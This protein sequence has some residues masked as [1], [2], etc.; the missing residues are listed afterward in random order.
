MTTG[1]NPDG[2]K[3][4]QDEAFALLG[5]CLTSPQGIDPLSERALRKLAE[6]CARS[7]HNEHNLEFRKPSIQQRGFSRAGA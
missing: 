4:T 7:N 3:L 2:L 6:F 1:D 5:L